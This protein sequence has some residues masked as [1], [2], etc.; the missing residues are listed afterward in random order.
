MK[1]GAAFIRLWGSLGPG[2]LPFADAATR[3]L[4]LSR[5]MRLSLFQVSVGMTAVLLTGTLNR[6]MIVEL[7]V[8][9]TLVAIMAGL[10][11]VF[12]PLRT[13]VG[14]RSDHHRSYLGWR[15]VPYIWFGSLLQ[16]GGLAIMP[17]ALLV[18]SGEGHA[19]VAAGQ[20]GAALAFLLTGAGMHMTQT[21]GLAL[22]SDLSEDENRPRVVALLYVM[23]LAGM[24]VSALLLG[25]L[26]ADFSPKRLIQV[27]QG[28]A[29]TSMILTSIAL[30]K[31][32]PRNPALKPKGE[33]RPA[34]WQVWRSFAGE[35]QPGRLLA[36]VALG[37]AAFGMQDILLEPYGGEVLKLSVGQTTLLTAMAA[38]GSIAGFT[39]AAGWI[40]RAADPC[41]VAAI[42]VLTGLSAFTCVLLSGAMQLPLL[43]Q[44]GV[45][46][47]GLGSGL[48]SVGTLIA[49]MTL[50]RRDTSGLALGAW[51][52]VQATS[53]GCA[54]AAG[55][56]VRDAAVASAPSLPD[57][58]WMSPAY[59]G[60]GAVYHIEIALLFATLIALGPLVR[61]YSPSADE[62]GSKFGLPELPG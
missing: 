48:F 57:S 44:I 49:V 45:T 20:V 46:L 19:P 13:L 52:A 55:G 8:P 47:I 11:L 54:L 17:F 33:Q 60:Y 36:T 4:P 29:L 7:N 2:L 62:R 51:G 43:F 15:R 56:I 27:V 58:G 24:L 14:F 10:P 35:V 50:A 21:A 12:A 25:T 53:L 16:F 30:W 28:C 34:F 23:L 37:T 39:L 40:K 5:L 42:G 41:R 32:E 3:D 6:V 22:A 9:A 1:V 38:A 18:L 31:Q 61:R 26:L 59:A